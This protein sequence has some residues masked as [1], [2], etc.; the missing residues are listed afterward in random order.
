MLYATGQQ[1]GAAAAWEWVTGES[2][3]AL[4]RQENHQQ[5]HR[6]N[7]SDSAA[8]AGWGFTD[9]S[10]GSRQLGLLGLI[11]WD[12][13]SVYNVGK[14]SVKLLQNCDGCSSSS[15]ES[16]LWQYPGVTEWWEICSVFSWLKSGR[17]RTYKDRNSALAS[18]Y[19]LV[20]V[21]YC[22]HTET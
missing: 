7:D 17:C 14:L 20:T 5:R 12:I 19:L 18:S 16:I 22:D 3:R 15:L 21:L 2:L 13:I 4:F 6:G 9:A 10:V 8:F 1:F 11:C